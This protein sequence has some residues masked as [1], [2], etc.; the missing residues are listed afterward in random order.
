MVTSRKI[1]V[2]KNQSLHSVIKNDSFSYSSIDRGVKLLKMANGIRTNKFK[3]NRI[4]YLP[5]C[6]N[7]KDKR[8]I[9]SI[10]KINSTTVKNKNNNIDRT[11]I[12][13]G[14]NSGALSLKQEDRALVSNYLKFS[15]GSSYNLEKNYSI[16]ANVHL[17]KY[18]NFNVKNRATRAPESL[19]GELELSLS[20][21]FGKWK[22]AIGYDRLNFFIMEENEITA[23]QINR[24]SL[25][26]FYSISNKLKVF[27]GLGYINDFSEKE[28]TGIDLSLGTSLRINN[29]LNLSLYGYQSEINTILN[30]QNTST[31][32]GITLSYGF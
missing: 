1:H 17:T 4:I 12:N 11:R 5:F 22:V 2:K 28:I 13:F 24:F 23:N 10:N 18:F 31:A 8:N 27:A 6:I 30:N 14:M 19:Y 9:A 15:L 21:R 29:E 26:P 16:N 20:K 3:D 32:Y 25:K 7:K